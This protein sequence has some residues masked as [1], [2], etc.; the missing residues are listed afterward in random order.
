MLELY[1]FLLA[2]G[3]FLHISGFYFWTRFNLDSR[4]RAERRFAMRRKALLS[5][6]VGSFFTPI[7]LWII[8]WHLADKTVIAML[9]ANAAV[10]GFVLCVFGYGSAALCSWQSNVFGLPRMPV[11]FCLQSKSARRSLGFT[12]VEGVD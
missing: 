12:I 10:L 8:S 11:A 3:V 6:F 4:K 9:T 7:M 5:L 1:V 2:V